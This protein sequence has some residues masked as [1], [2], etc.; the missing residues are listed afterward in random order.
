MPCIDL[1]IHSL[2]SD[3]ALAPS[4]LVSRAAAAGM[5]ALA[6]TDHD[7]V[8]G[9]AEAMAA[10]ERLG[11]MVVPGIEISVSWRGCSLHMLGYWFD[12]AAPGLQEWLAPLQRGR[13]QRNRQILERLRELGVEVDE[14]ELARVAGEGQ[15]GRPHIARLLV[16]KGVVADIEGAFVRYLRRGAAAYVARFAYPAEEAIAM[17]HHL[18]GIAVLAH[19]GQ[20]NLDEPGMSALFGSLRA[21]GLDGIEG[22][23]PSHSFR[24]TRR[25]L[26]LAR[27][28]DLAISGGSDFHADYQGAGETWPPGR[29]GC[30]P[31][32]LLEALHRRRRPSMEQTAAGCC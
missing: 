13:E 25:L 15:T 29:I 12:P 17:L 11:C 31:E 10:G 27:R 24:C 23:H 9:L 7:T 18:G 8:A 3:G 22:Y 1:H 32:N 19:P 14:E 30:V 5:A 26:T 16:A 28:Y 2:F 4:Q 20:L 21:S 6:L